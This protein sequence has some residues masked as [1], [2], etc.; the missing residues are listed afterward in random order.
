[1]TEGQDEMK[2]LQVLNLEQFFVGLSGSGPR[3]GCSRNVRDQDSKSTKI[4]HIEGSDNI[5]P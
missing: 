3:H 2:L 4:K 5:P 1:M